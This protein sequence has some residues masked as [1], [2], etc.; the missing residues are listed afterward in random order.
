[1]IWLLCVRF[2]LLL[3]EIRKTV[4]LQ[5]PC[6]SFLIWSGVRWMGLLWIVWALRNSSVVWFTCSGVVLV[7]LTGVLLSH[8]QR[9]ESSGKT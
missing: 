1:M 6:K 5:V 9:E 4:F 8:R 7:D 2:A 3:L